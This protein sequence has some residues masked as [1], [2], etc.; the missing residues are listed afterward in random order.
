M[1]DRDRTTQLLKRFS[2]GDTGVCDALFGAIEAELHKL[3]RM[4]MAGRERAHTLQS[5]ALVHEAWLRLIDA[6]DATFPSR[7]HFYSMASKVMRSILVD[8][9]RRKA[10]EKRGGDRVRVTLVEGAGD[11]PDFSEADVL[12]LHD[13]LGRLEAIDAE[14]ARIVELRYFGGLTMPDLAESVGLP[15]RTVERRLQ[16]ATAWLRDALR[17]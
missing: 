8:H 14:R 15:L 11:E 3:A 2:D 5:T 1:A 7:G 4:H 16:A 17:G 10:A 6:D 12:D 9:A 13:A